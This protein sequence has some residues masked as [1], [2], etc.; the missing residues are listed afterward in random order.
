MVF[1]ISLFCNLY[2]PSHPSSLHLYD[3]CQLLTISLLFNQTSSR[4]SAALWLCTVHNQV[5]ER[6]KKPEFDCAH[7]DE[8]YDC[9]CGDEPINKNSQPQGGESGPDTG[10]VGKGHAEDAK[11]IKTIHQIYLLAKKK[12]QRDELT[13]AGLI[14]GGR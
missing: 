8:E 10:I 4:R 1:F 5:N 12:L 7:L 9:G 14:R 6:L 3:C 11:V 13:G 2:F